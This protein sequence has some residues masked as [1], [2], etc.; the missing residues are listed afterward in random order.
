MQIFNAQV[1][2]IISV[3]VYVCMHSQSLYLMIGHW[4]WNKRPQKSLIKMFAAK[5]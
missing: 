2:K 1:R 3:C 5:N 4:G